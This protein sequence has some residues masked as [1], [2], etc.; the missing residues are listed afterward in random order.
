MLILMFTPISNYMASML[1]VP[2]I[3]KKVDL[4]VVLGG[5]AYRNS[6]LSGSSSERLLHGLRLH[7][8]GLSAKIVFVGGTIL[9]SGDK[10]KET[11]SEETYKAGAGLDVVEAS[12]MKAVAEDIGVRRADILLDIE[13]ANTYE[14]IRA[15]KA[16]M[17]S[18]DFDTCMIVT[19]PTHM[20]RAIRVARKFA[21]DCTPA[22]VG[23]YTSFVDDPVGRLS[24]MRA[25]LR[26]Y[27][28]L[29]IYKAFGYI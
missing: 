8:Q 24:L 21:L 17:D 3:I 9:D 14:N 22:P 27:A 7:R 10:L 4:T 23:D 6:V 29:F 26:E 12:L 5:G 16:L 11:L 15:V 19:S 2:M 13:S 18:N 1:T 25:V 20:L 28:A